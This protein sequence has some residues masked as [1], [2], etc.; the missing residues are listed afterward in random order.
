MRW[1]RL[2]SRPRASPAPAAE[3]Q[4]ARALP[5]LNTTGRL[6][7]IPPPPLSAPV[8]RR[9]ELAAGLCPPP[10]AEQAT[11]CKEQG[12]AQFGGAEYA[13]HG[14]NCS[15]IQTGPTAQQPYSVANLSPHVPV[16]ACAGLH[17][18]QSWK[19]RTERATDRLSPAA[20]VLPASRRTAAAELTSL[21]SPPLLNAHASRSPTPPWRRAQ[22]PPASRNQVSTSPPGSMP[23]AAN[24][25]CLPLRSLPP[26]TA[27]F[28][29]LCS[30]R[31]AQG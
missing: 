2:L 7:T 25:A 28:A 8:L 6:P 10:R 27:R 4:Q 29:L 26:L 14:A 30:Q 22:R 17:T 18:R 3:R 20:R 21:P 23:A 12:D 5:V 9:L 11:G 1:R 31:G 19:C 16:A 24:A 15:V 13:R